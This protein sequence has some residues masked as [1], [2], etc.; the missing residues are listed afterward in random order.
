MDPHRILILGAAGR[1]FHLFNTL[2]RDD[3]GVEV[4]AFTA[5]QIPHIDDRRYPPELAGDLYPD[6]IP[7]HPEDE[8][9][10]LILEHEIESVV[11]AYSDLAYDEVG[12]LMARA[13][14]MGA[15]F[16]VP[17][18]W[19]TMI[20]SRLPVVAITAA[21]TGVGKSQTSRAV[22]RALRSEGLRVGIIRHPMPYGDLNK[23]RVQ[24]FASEEDLV[25]HE[26]TIEER[27]E[28]EPHIAAGTVVYAGVDYGEIL[29]A[30]EDE[31]DVIIWDGGNNDTPFYVPDVWLTLVDPHRPGH[32]RRFYPGETN[33]RLADVVV[34][35]K[36]D[37]AVAEDVEQVLANVAELNTDAVVLHAA[38]PITPDDA[39]VLAGKKVIAVEDGPTCTHGGMAYGAG[40]LGAEAA[41]AGEIVD[42]RPF[43]VGELRETF[44]K[45]PD[46]GPILPAMGYGETQIR[47]LEATL[48]KAAEHG[49]EAVAIGT[50]ID[51]GHLVD[52]P[53]PH[54]RCRYELAVQ[55]TPTLEDVLSP[56]VA[57]AR[58]EVV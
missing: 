52:L 48:R 32:E 19:S 20:E 10:D 34:V 8:L 30:A 38:S 28:Y 42:P 37:T 31:S 29:T 40:L 15:D 3:D 54:T 12:H 50:P 56:V 14:A 39:A 7:I 22:A 4:V 18:A 9:E 44:E 17:D 33:V 23:Q 25:A 36:I 16:I 49:V 6:G 53:I 1:D 57:M 55:G 58:G 5:Q 43:L 47:D 21:R 46:L 26:V 24:R 13:T 45:Y 51:L 11:L 41:G 27:E 2:Y 35:N